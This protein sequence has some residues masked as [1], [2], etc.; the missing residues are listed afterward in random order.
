MNLSTRKMLFKRNYIK[1]VGE[2]CDGLAPFQ[3]NENGLWGYIDEKRR[4]VIKP[5]YKFVSEFREEVAFV[6]DG[7]D[8]FTI[9]KNGNRIEESNFK[10]KLSHGIIIA[11]KTCYAMR[12]G[13]VV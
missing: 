9:D 4:I 13:D 1:N 10:L 3:S 12:F 6:N 2:F 8:T 7:R 5:K 11:L